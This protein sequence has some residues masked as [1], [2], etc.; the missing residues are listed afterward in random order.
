M[1]FTPTLLRRHAPLFAAAL[2]F[3]LYGW[4]MVAA[5]ATCHDGAIGPAFNAVGAD[6][7]IWQT[8]AGAIFHHGLAHIYDQLWITQTV[9][10]DYAAWLSAPEPYPVFPYPP[11]M[12]LL[13]V[14]FALLPMPL[15][16][17]LFELLS[18]A[19]LAWAL[20][21]LAG[22]KVAWL[23]L[24]IGVALSPAAANNIMAGQ[25]AFLTAA[26]LTGGFSLLSTR[27]ATAG[28]LLGLMLFKPQYFPLIAVALVALKSWRALGAMAATALLLSL[29]SAA[30]FGLDIWRAWANTFLHP[31]AIPGG[32]NGNDWGHLWDSSVATCLQ[33]LGAPHWAQTGGQG[34]AALAAVALVWRAFRAEL[35]LPAR[36]AVLCCATLLASPHV[37]SYDMVLLALAGLIAV[38]RLGA[39]ARPLVLL[40]PL[41]AYTAPLYNPPR[42]SPLGEATPLLLLALAGW[43]LASSRVPKPMLAFHTPEAV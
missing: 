18:F 9:N 41:A 4:A 1:P 13:V 20:R 17:L 8:A 40:L 36:L 27:P 7:V 10:H 29:T 3:G 14:P 37:S 34:L 35:D 31:Q 25:N 2:L 28:A 38:A 6:W 16:M 23:F 15:S 24:V 5:T 42:A 22:E 26:L 43:F 32:I 11:V 19:A 33:M 12:L 39:T 21:K 30:L